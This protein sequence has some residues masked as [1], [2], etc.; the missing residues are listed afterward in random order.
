VEHLTKLAQIIDAGELKVLVKRTFPL[1]DVQDA[2]QL[3]QSDKA[4]GKN[5]LTI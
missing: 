1:A 2:L 5:V 3:Q 4:P